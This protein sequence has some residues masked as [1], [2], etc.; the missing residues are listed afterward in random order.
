MTERLS[1]LALP[2]EELDHSEAWVQEAA[3]KEAKIMDGGAP[4]TFRGFEALDEIMDNFG[5]DSRELVRDKVV[6]D[7]GSGMGGLA[8]SVATEGINATVWSINPHLADPEF[9]WVEEQATEHELRRVYPDIDA[10]QIAAA[11]AYH[12]AHLSTA[13]A[14]NL[15]FPDETFDVLL[16]VVA[17]NAYTVDGEAALY[18]R[19]ICEMMRVLK[20]GGR[21]FIVDGFRTGIGA[22]HRETG[23]PMFKEQTLQKLGIK[24]HPVYKQ[25][26]DDNSIGAI[27]YK[28]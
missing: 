1:D 17:V 16:D 24:Y 20:P 6:G 23:A 18:E 2:P 14:H 8:K 12:D 10:E 7:I 9:K 28:N 3:A 25:G 26:S 15:D 11:Q 21:A 19:T 27:L 5:V 13:F 4:D 22:K